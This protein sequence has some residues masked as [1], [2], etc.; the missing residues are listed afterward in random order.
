MTLTKWDA[1]FSVGVAALDKKHKDLLAALDELY[2]A[3][4]NGQSK[5][6]IGTTM[7][8]LD[9]YCHVHLAHEEHF[10]AKTNYPD[11]AVH[12]KEHDDLR[13]QIM[14]IQAKCRENMGGADAIN[15]MNL[16]RKWL[17]THVL[18]VDQKYTGHLTANGI[19]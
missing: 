1:S 16:L 18:T 10:F 7:E 15:L 3:M 9:Y 6:I 11:A 14:E 17:I 19:K 13:K 4:K 8:K 12:M 2:E 5:D